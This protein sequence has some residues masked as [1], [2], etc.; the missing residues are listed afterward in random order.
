MQKTLAYEDMYSDNALHTMFRMSKA[1]ALLPAD[2]II[3]GFEVV[4]SEA[5]LSPNIEIAEK[6]IL[7]FKNKW[8]ER[9]LF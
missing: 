1:L 2:K 6:Y 8:M 5:R 9:E 4:V 7:Y 3:E